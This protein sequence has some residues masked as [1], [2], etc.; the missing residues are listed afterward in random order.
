[1]WSAAKGMGA[2]YTIHYSLIVLFESEY[3]CRHSFMCGGGFVVA[4]VVI[5]D[6]VA[7]QVSARH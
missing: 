4:A 5:A 7:E 6:R 3:L 1:M 2:K